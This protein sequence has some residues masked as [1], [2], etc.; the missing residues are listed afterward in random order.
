[1]GIRKTTDELLVKVVEV[2]RHVVCV[3]VDRDLRCV[4]EV[5]DCAGE[6]ARLASRLALEARQ[7]KKRLKVWEKKHGKGNWG[8]GHPCR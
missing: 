5:K 7:L 3:L 2:Q 8:K 6:T 4:D 1:M